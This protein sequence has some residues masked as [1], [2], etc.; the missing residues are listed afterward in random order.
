MDHY[1]ILGVAED[2]NQ[3]TIRAAY[4]QKAFQ[5]HPDQNRDD[6]DAEEMFKSISQAYS[7]LSDPDK[8]RA[9]DKA[10]TAEA[11]GRDEY[12][13]GH[14]T[15]EGR[16][17]DEDAASMNMGD[18]MRQFMTEAYSLAWEL[19]MT[20][21]RVDDIT[22]RLAERGCPAEI[23]AIIAKGVTQQR[24][25]MVRRQAGRLAVT[26]VAWLVGGVVLLIVLSG[27]KV[28]WISGL[29][30]IGRAVW[31]L[32]KALY[33]VTTGRIPVKTDRSAGTNTGSTSEQ[34]QG[35]RQTSQNA[36]TTETGPG[37]HPATW[38]C[39][40]CGD[41]NLWA[42]AECRSCGKLRRK[43]RSP[44]STTTSTNRGNNQGSWRCSR[45]GDLNSGQS[46]L[47]RSC[48]KRRPDRG[49]SGKGRK[50]GDGASPGTTKTTHGKTTYWHKRTE[51]PDGSSSSSGGEWRCSNCG[52]LNDANI[53]RCES[54]AAW[55]YG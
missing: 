4:R 14:A 36:R 21:A 38:R 23:A 37:T 41:T 43:R 22:R 42:Q 5:W 10:R 51:S 25:T 17:R 6:R 54:C 16:G 3:E 32:L 48:G 40:R 33:H 19:S 30:L 50:S 2:A 1:A 12:R 9:Y 44:D 28:L 29:V 18:A 55:R 47:C 52:T 15:S 35:R 20:N 46:Q 26:A 49:R 11:Y 45:C 34:R 27:T 31:L 7:V 24:R 39:D 8:R 13:E 53:A